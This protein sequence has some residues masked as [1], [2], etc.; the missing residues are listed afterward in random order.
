MNHS[1][2][3]VLALALILG[4]G[5]APAARADDTEEAKEHFRK[6]QTHYA[7]GEFEEAAAEFREAYRL[8][9]APT[10]LYN[11]AQAMRLLGQHKQSLFYYKQYLSKK[12]DANN[13]AD[14]ESTIEVLKQK[15]EEEEQDEQVQKA[16]AARRD[17]KPGAPGSAAAAPGA[18]KAKPPAG[19]KP[20]KPGPALASTTK[21]AS[22]GSPQPD[23]P[24]LAASR[25]S[26]PA[27]ALTAPSDSASRGGVHVAGYVAMGAGVAVEGL[28]FLFHSSAQSSADEL[29]KK[30]AAGT[31][32]PSDS[33][34]KDDVS[35]KGKLATMSVIGGAVL[36]A[37][38]AAMVFAF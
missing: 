17:V 1:K 29:S 21:A 19:A 6:G 9:D 10:I 25:P 38:G 30:Y 18:A 3:T 20:V 2:T 31:L 16:A 7:L 22:R 12:P 8:K 5:R 26:V 35:S 15:I 32:Q 27:A 36:I 28:A 23:A 33:K 24:E 13:R 37:A 4:L 11:I 34:L 14:V